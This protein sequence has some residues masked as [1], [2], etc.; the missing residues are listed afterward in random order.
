MSQSNIEVVKSLHKAFNRRDTQTFL[1]LLD[2]AVEW[3]PMMAR[4]E[5]TVYR[6]RSEVEGWLAGLDHDWEDL[7]TDPREFRDFGDVVLILGTWH[8]RAR[9]SGLVL[10]SEPGAWVAHVR[11]GKVVRQETFTD[12]A[13]ALEA[14]ELQERR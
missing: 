6:G 12:R 1:D 4:L 11:N 2:P 7:R 13:Q 3:V 14:A 10:D 8:A 5:G 9:S